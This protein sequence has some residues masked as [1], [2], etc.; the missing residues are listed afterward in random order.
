MCIR[1]RRNACDRIVGKYFIIRDDY[2][3]N[4]QNKE[5]EDTLIKTDRNK[6]IRNR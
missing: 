5:R 1:D 6:K 3:R 4:I 2:N